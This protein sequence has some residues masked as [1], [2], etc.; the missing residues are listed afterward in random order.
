VSFF[1]RSLV[2]KGLDTV[3]SSAIGGIGRGFVVGLNGLFAITP[4]RHGPAGRRGEAC[5]G[6]RKTG[7]KVRAR[8][9]GFKLLQKDWANSR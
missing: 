9:A 2:P 8:T 3:F 6:G 5:L 4:L 7:S 1:V